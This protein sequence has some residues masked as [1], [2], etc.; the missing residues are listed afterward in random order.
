[1]ARTT[2]NANSHNPCMQTNHSLQENHTMP[3]PQSNYS[4]LFIFLS[5]LLSLEIDLSLSCTTPFN[6]KSPATV[7]LVLV[8]GI[9]A[10]GLGP[11]KHIQKRNP[12]MYQSVHHLTTL[13]SPS[14]IL[15]LI[16]SQEEEGEREV[17][18]RVVQHFPN[19]IHAR[20]NKALVSFPS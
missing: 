16:F 9:W 11:K 12:A 19:T 13:I 1:M 5:F 7:V 6:L 4:L 20:C 10:L 8:F 14:L 2:I 17:E 3:H 15:L 18:K